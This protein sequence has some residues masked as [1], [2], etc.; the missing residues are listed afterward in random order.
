[1]GQ[2]STGEFSGAIGGF[3]KIAFA[4]DT[5]LTLATAG[6]KTVSNTAWE[7]DFTDRAEEFVDTAVLSGAAFAENTTVEVS[8]TDAAQAAAGWSIAS[9]S[10]AA[11][12]TFDLTI[13]GTQVAENLAYPSVESCGCGL[14]PSPVRLR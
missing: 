5:A 2:G 10:D 3:A 9:V 12:A 14:G 13:G 8:F 1:M 4:G 11:N 7:F 6:S